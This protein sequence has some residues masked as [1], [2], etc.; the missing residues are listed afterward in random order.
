[1]KKKD[2]AE[3][4]SAAQKEAAALQTALS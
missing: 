3:R 1:L 4:L 2:A